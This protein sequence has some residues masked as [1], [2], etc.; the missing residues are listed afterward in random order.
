MG[1]QR[2]KYTEEQI[3]QILKEAEV[4]NN[5]SDTLRKYGVN[6]S[7][8]YRWKAKYGGM[9]SKSILRLR[10]LERENAR[11]KRIVAEQ[12]LDITMLKDINS[13][14]LV[15]PEVRRTRRCVSYS[16]LHSGGGSGLRASRDI[17]ERV[18]I[19]QE[20]AGGDTARAD[21]ATCEGALSLGLSAVVQ[22]H[23]STRRKCKPQEVF[24]DLPRRTSS[25][26]Q[27]KP[28]Q[29]ASFRPNKKRRAEG[30][31]R[32]MEYGFY[33]RRVGEQEEL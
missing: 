7:S 26:R 5:V 3:T 23:S 18:C 6:D 31:K 22:L 14:K 28:S 15:K 4:S 32:K 29:G 11:L 25:N 27:K 13:K 1:K 24:E 2:K 8:Y 33:V 30:N 17:E 16:D 9:E 12:M 10:E 21:K 20:D 19:P